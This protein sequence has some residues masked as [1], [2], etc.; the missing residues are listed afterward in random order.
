MLL[1]ILNGFKVLIPI[2]LYGKVDLENRNGILFLFEKL[3]YVLILMVNAPVA[4]L[5][6]AL[7]SGSKGRRFESSRAYKFIYRNSF[8]IRILIEK[9]HNK[10]YIM[11]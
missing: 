11:D 3:I 2:F 9:L 5:D 8:L 7:D 6:R 4:Q 1:S 10:Y